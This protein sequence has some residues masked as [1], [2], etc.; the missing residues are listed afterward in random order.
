[1]EWLG[2]IILA[3]GMIRGHHSRPPTATAPAS[4][5]AQ[6][7]CKL[8]GLRV[9]HS[10]RDDPWQVTSAGKLRSVRLRVGRVGRFLLATTYKSCLIHQAYDLHVP[11]EVAATILV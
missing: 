10:D 6:L 5:V 2:G 9:A 3:H 1:M 7:L 11:I 8:H 4:R